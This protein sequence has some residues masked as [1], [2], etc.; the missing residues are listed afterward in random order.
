MLVSGFGGFV[1][2]FPFSL[3]GGFEVYITVMT[4]ISKLPVRSIDW[5][6]FYNELIILDFNDR[7][8]NDRLKCG[9]HT[10]TQLEGTNLLGTPCSIGTQ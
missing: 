5:P 7:M 3:D 2:L 8:F 4:E 9:N 1:P 10:W 6:P